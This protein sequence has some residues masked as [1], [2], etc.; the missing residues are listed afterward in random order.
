MS[1]HATSPNPTLSRWL[2]DTGTSWRIPSILGAFL[3][4][5]SFWVMRD[6]F[7]MGD[8]SVVAITGGLFALG[9]TFSAERRRFTHQSLLITGLFVLVIHP[10]FYPGV[11]FGTLLLYVAILQVLQGNGAERT[12]RNFLTI[13]CIAAIYT[14]R[15][16]KVG[17]VD[18]TW[19]EGAI[20]L[21]LVL[22]TLWMIAVRSH[23]WQA[24]KAVLLT[25]LEASVAAV[26]TPRK[27]ATVN[28]SRLQ[29]MVLV[30]QTTTDRQRAV[31]FN[32]MNACL[33]DRFGSGTLNWDA[34]QEAYM[35]LDALEAFVELMS[36]VADPMETRWTSSL[37]V[38][39]YTGEVNINFTQPYWANTLRAVAYRKADAGILPEADAR[40]WAVDV[41]GLGLHNLISKGW[42]AQ[43]KG[44]VLNLSHRV[45]VPGAS[46]VDGSQSLKNKY[47]PDFA[48]ENPAQILVAEDNPV[49]QKLV[50]FMLEKLGYS[51]TLAHDGLQAVEAAKHTQ[52]D[53]IFM[54]LHMPNLDGIEATKSILS[55]TSHRPVIVPLTANVSEESQ[56]AC[57]EVGMF[58]FIAK[59]FAIKDLCDAVVSALKQ[60]K[61]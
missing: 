50:V 48:K 26:E 21:S 49:N 2:S 60:P 6:S 45:N 1:A 20:S 13:S 8:I 14:I 18:F 58:G 29:D 53:L 23:S 10:G 5:F 25:D 22:L 32:G 61:G 9:L 44:N 24:E 41:F 55:D 3:A 57:A 40:N 4:L 28:A 42:N 19:V 43:I 36:N 17:I 30:Q 39:N 37:T 34:D 38:S 52:F 16:V 51:I 35:P 33:S 12:I 46:K 31:S 59:P 7:E 54:D 56:A 27:Q 47:T 15:L 11:G